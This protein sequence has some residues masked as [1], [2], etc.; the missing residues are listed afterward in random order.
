MLMNRVII[1][2]IAVFSSFT[3]L[4]SGGTDG[5]G[6]HYNR[7]TGEYHYHHGYSAH[8]HYDM[9]GDGV[10]DCPYSFKNNTSY[11]SSTSKSKSDTNSSSKSSSNKKHSNSFKSFLESVLLVICSIFVSAAIT[12]VPWALRS[13]FSVI[14]KYTNRK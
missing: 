4:H 6:G 2:L 5:S 12:I 9:D 14:R 3:V 1:G 8:S 11:K 13:I 10:A 7:S